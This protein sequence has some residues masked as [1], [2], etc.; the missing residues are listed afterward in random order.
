MPFKVQSLPAEKDWG[1]D[2]GVGWAQG[3]GPKGRAWPF[4]GNMLKYSGTT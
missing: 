1:E 3:E 4:R 2:G